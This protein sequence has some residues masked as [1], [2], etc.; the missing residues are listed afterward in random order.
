MYRFPNGES[1]TVFNRPL[2][3]RTPALQAG[4]FLFYVSNPI[5]VNSIGIDYFAR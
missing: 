5:S 3:L 4:V 2:S 1:A